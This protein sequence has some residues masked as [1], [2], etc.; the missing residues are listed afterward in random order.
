MKEEAIWLLDIIDSGH[1]EKR[2]T[3][4]HAPLEIFTRILDGQSPETLVVADILSGSRFAET[5][6]K[7]QDIL[8]EFS[9]YRKFTDMLSEHA[10]ALCGYTRWHHW[11][12]DKY[13]FPKDPFCRSPPLR[14]PIHGLDRRRR[15]A[16]P[17]RP[18]QRCNAGRRRPDGV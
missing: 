5:L 12:N 9:R 7:K 18:R 14:A 11:E 2:N 4:I 16:G 6:S 17:L 10:R 3:G 8:A 1:A 15:A 13:H